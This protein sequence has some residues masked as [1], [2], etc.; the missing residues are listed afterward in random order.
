MVFKSQT[1][2]LEKIDLAETKTKPFF[3]LTEMPKTIIS[4]N[5]SLFLT[6]PIHAQY[7]FIFF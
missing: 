3:I 4:G 2:I 5:E 1:T 6:E 7:F